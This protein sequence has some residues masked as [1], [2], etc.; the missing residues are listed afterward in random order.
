MAL[1]LGHLLERYPSQLSGGQQQRVAIGRAIV[2]EPKVFLFDEPFSNLDA[3]LRNHM[4]GEVKE[5]HERLGVTSIFVTH[6]QEEALSISDRIAVMRQGAVEQVGTP[7]E[8]YARPATA[9][10]ARFIGN[11]RIELLPADVEEESGVAFAVCGE[12]RFALDCAQAAFLRKH[13]GRIDL[14]LRPEHVALAEAGI[15]A[16]VRDV[17]PVGPS[18]LVGLAWKGGALTARLNG[19]IRMAPGTAVF[20]R[21]DCSKLMFFDRADGR[22]I[23][24]SQ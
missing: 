23:D 1:D 17:Q 7:E 6:D 14:G 9:Y 16:T 12:A 19:I 11:P 4:R 15:A 18:T 5:L 8:V 3:A 22:R 13:C 2:R 20:A 24:T 10:V 21:P